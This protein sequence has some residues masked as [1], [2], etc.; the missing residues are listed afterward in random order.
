MNDYIV[1]YKHWSL[2]E[3]PIKTQRVVYGT[4]PPAVSIVY[5]FGF[6]KVDPEFACS[7][8]DAR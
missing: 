1:D 5:D 8:L 2:D 7:L 3:P 4:R 6:L